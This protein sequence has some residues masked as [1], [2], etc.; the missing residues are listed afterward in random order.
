M[1]QDEPVE[2]PADPDIGN[3]AQL[4]DGH[5]AEMVRLAH[6]LL[7]SNTA[8]EDVVQ[9]AFVEMQKHWDSVKNPV[10][11]LRKSVVNGSRSWHRSRRRE[12]A[13]A[14]RWAGHESVPFEARELLDALARLP[15][16]QRAALVLRYY[17]DLPDA[18]IASLLVCPIG[19]VKSDLHRG[20]ARL[21]PRHPASCHSNRGTPRLPQG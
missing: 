18:E 16:R 13:R 2:V 15:V 9:T 8:A 12:R 14:A 6:V 7:G 20:L 1:G 3:L 10:A 21:R 5:Y 11:Y 19:T 17:E 4:F